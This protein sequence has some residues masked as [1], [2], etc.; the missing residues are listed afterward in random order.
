MYLYWVH[1][2]PVIVKLNKNT[3][4]ET[5]A[6]LWNQ[7]KNTGDKVILGQNMNKSKEDNIHLPD[8]ATFKTQYFSQ[9]KWICWN[10]WIVKPNAVEE[11]EG[12]VLGADEHLGGGVGG[13]Q[14]ELS[15][16]LLRDDTS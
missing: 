5:L 14:Q 2:E 16:A 8:F 6:V 9:Q 7:K 10:A 1:I 11:P 15:H 3:K 13:K 12:E 4:S